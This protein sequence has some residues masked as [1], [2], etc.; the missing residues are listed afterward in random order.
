MKLSRMMQRLVLLFLML[1]LGAGLQAQGLQQNRSSLY[2]YTGT[3]GAN[4]SQFND[5]LKE[6]G[7]SPLQNR[8]RSY[9]LGYQARVNDFILG[10]ELSQH[11]GRPSDL[12]GYRINYRASRAFLNL[13]YSLTEEG[14]FQLIHYLSLGMGYLNFQMLP[15]GKEKDLATF[16]TNPSQ[17]FILRKNDI[18][19]GSA[20]FGDF[21]T[22]IGFQLSYDFPIPNRKEALKVVAKAGYSFSPFEGSWALNGIS[23][24]N[25]Q[26]GAFFR[27]GTGISLPDRNFFYKD[28]TLGVS[29]IR[30]IHF[31]QPDRFNAVLQEKGYQPLEGR[32]NNVG[33][34]ILGETDGLLYGMD[35]FNLSLKGKAS[36]TQ[37]HSLNSLRVYANV[38][39]KF[40][41]YKNFGFGVL[42][43]LGYGN[44]RYS[45]LQD[46]KPDFP[47]LLDL[48]QKAY[49]GYLKNSGILLKPE[50]LLEYGLPMTKSKFFDLVF[51]TTAGYEAAFPGY[52]LGGLAMNAYQSGPFISFGL[53]VRPL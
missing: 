32:P 12:E 7:H 36:A 18:Q 50:V 47:V 52:K 13:G 37:S 28:A 35:V 4:L 20:Y 17:G 43:G 34:R 25:A 27:I 31:T 33:L 15:R 51:S 38:G 19:K 5:L 41:Q 6:R 39:K 21:L 53:G 46:Q 44:L 40:F 2:V 3:S 49:D 8:Y 30:G 26:A 10:V 14:K 23:F 42:G 16:L 22:E 45:L 24:D 1:L 11:Q 9:G 48:D 29:L